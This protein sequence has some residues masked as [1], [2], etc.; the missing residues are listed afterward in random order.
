MQA[1]SLFAMDFATSYRL[2][3]HWRAGM[4]G[5]ALRQL[6]DSRA[7]GQRIGQ[8][9]QQV[10]ALG[11]AGQWSAPGVMVRLNGFREFDARNRP[12]GWAVVGR[13]LLPF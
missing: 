4:A 10:L 1:G 7:N 2:D 6:D 5:Y 3:T 8:S 12:E 13:L 11:P 9:M